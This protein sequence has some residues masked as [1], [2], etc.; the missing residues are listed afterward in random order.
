MKLFQKLLSKIFLKN[1][2]IL[3]LAL[4]LFFTGI[5]LMQNFKNLPPSANLQII[6]ATNI[7]LNFMN[8]TLPLSL[9]FSML[10][11]IFQLIRSNE[12]VSLYALGTSKREVITP[13]FLLS[14]LITLLYIGLNNT[15][16]VK[17]NEYADSIKKHGKITNTSSHLF[18]KSHNDYVYIESLRPLQ[19]EGRNIKIFQTK[20]TDLQKIIEA[21]RA[22][23]K[24]DHWELQ[25]VTEII[26]PDI[27]QKGAKLHY[28]TL[29]T[30]D[31]L[32]GFKPQIIDNLFKGKS[33]L[34]I[35]DSLSAIT[36]LNAQSLKTDKIRANL[37][38]MILFPL[39][40]PIAILALFYPMPAQRRA[41]NLALLSTLYIFG[42]LMLWG[43]L[44]TLAKISSNGALLPEF[45]IILPLILLLLLSLYLIYKNR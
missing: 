28:K 12:L 3:F 41:S 26:K 24:E 23:F 20:G 17:A 8:Y 27:N 9:L 43:I 39:F 37:Y 36:L 21:K 15:N 4:E 16:F 44:F 29:S 1:F 30:L 18:L 45:G 7:F 25:E 33:K 42:I 31:A 14:L 19:K 40:A 11:T 35:Q 22:I 10:M 34:T 2:I 6:Y 32:E 5:D 13:I 38:I